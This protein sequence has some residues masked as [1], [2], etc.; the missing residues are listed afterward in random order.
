MIIDNLAKNTEKVKKVIR[1]V[2][3][4]INAMKRDCPCCN[5]LHNAIITQGDMIPTTVKKDLEI[6]IAKHLK[7]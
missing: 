2:L 7:G 5:A 3:P 1:T 6:I 4:E